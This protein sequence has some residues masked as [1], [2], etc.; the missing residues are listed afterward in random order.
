MA[1]R[2]L[3]ARPARTLLTLLGIALGVAAIL[4]TSITNRHA[5]NTLDALFRRTLGSAEL[6]VMP[7]GNK[8][9]VSQSVLDEVRRSPAVRLAVP[10]LRADTVL[11]G[12]LGKGQ[13]ST[14]D[15]GLPEMGKTVQVV[16]IDPALEPQMRVYTLA[17]GRFPEPG[18]YEALVTA[19]LCRRKRP[20]AGARRVALRPG[21]H[22]RAADHRASWSTKARP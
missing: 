16:G 22:R 15:N 17:A 5:S 11:P 6:E 21:G 8:T 18:Q 3:R 10:L 13:V 20:G 2:N 1:W 4:A 7:L 9:T 19:A 14:T 12:T